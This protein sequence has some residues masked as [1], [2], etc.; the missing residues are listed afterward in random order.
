MSTIEM[1][2][3]RAVTAEEASAVATE[4]GIDFAVLRCDLEQFRMGMAVE[5]EHGLGHPDTDVTGSDPAITGR[6]A[7][8]HLREY[9]DYYTRLALMERDA[10]AYWS[11]RR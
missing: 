8:A 6:I 7:L 11:Q 2:A 5:L 10:D 1:P 9:P 3:R 4:L